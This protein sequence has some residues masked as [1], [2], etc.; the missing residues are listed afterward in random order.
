M[1]AHGEQQ[2][3]FNWNGGEPNNFLNN[4]QDGEPN[5][6]MLLSGNANQNG[7]WNDMYNHASTQKRVNYSKNNLVVCTYVVPGTEPV[8]EC[9]Y[10]WEAHQTSQGRKCLQVNKGKFKILTALSAC[11]AAGSE[12]A[13]P[14]N[15]KDNRLFSDLIGYNKYDLWIAAH[16]SNNEG[17]VLI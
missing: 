15:E 11:K 8:T 3:F 1:N 6:E 4:K 13:L 12:L 2:T 7:K 17:K 10:G 16:D 9:G 14:R 5:V